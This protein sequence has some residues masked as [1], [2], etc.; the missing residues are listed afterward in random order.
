M[1]LGAEDSVMASDKDAEKRKAQLLLDAQKQADEKAKRL[2]A[3]GAAGSE[4]AAPLATGSAAVS[5]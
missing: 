2:K 3:Q 4:A 1:C 5:G